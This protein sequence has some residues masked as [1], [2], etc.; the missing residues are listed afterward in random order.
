MAT[1]TKE[2]L[3]GMCEELLKEIL[4]NTVKERAEEKAAHEKAMAEINAVQR[5]YTDGL[6]GGGAPDA[7]AKK[8]KHVIS[9]DPY[10]GAGLKFGRFVRALAAGKQSG[11]DP[12]VIAKQ[13]GDG[14]LAE[15]IDEQEQKA[16]AAG[17]ISA[18]G[19]IVP[20]EYR[21]ELV[22]LL[23]SQSVIRA[24]G[25]PTIP[26]K[27][28]S[29]TM[30]R[31]SAAATAAY[32]GEN[33][34]IAISQLALEQVQL[35]AKKLAATTPVSNDLLRESDPSADAIIRDDL[36]QVMALREDLAFIRD[37][38]TANKPKGIRYTTSTANVFA[39]NGTPT[40][41]TVTD[42][43]FKMVRLV[44]SLNV[45]LV[46]PAW[47]L[48]TRSAFFIRKLRDGNGNY[49]FAAEMAQGKLLGFP[50]F[51]SNQIPENLGGGTNESEVYFVEMTQMIIAD[52]MSMEIETFPGGAYYDG[53][54]VQS[55]I[56][57][58]QTVVRAISKHDFGM[59][60]TGAASV[61]TTVLYI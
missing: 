1:V 6:V 51:E 16:L 22:E 60:H 50:Y 7:Y 30:P 49:A 57:L 61:L 35:A 58:D 37:D 8:A 45:M 20:D 54:N 25:C 47:F 38:G 11:R 42:E 40:L 52:Q 29:M 14:W 33:A 19:A 12:R 4:G 5:K 3:K 34:N 48:T 53:S 59:R 27:S 13:W 21:A 23:R 17:V 10:K 2:T 39:A 55:G 15:A 28:G 46:R 32:V 36:V 44:K 43:L 26:M 18:G 31:Q 41:T 56:S 9:G 24:A